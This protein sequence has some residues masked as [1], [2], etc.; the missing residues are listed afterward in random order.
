MKKL[1]NPSMKAALQNELMIL[2]LLQG[3]NTIGLIDHY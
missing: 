3:Q 1:S 2:K